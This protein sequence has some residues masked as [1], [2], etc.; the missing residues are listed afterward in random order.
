MSWT[1]ASLVPTGGSGPRESRAGHGRERA[2]T[3]AEAFGMAKTEEHYGKEIEEGYYPMVAVKGDL[4]YELMVMEVFDGKGWMMLDVST[5]LF[6]FGDE[7][8]PW[9][10]EG[11]QRE[12]RREA[13]LAAEQPMWT[14][15][16]N[17]VSLE[18]PPAIDDADV[19]WSLCGQW[20]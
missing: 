15:N 4:G 17:E 12:F 9:W 6:D 3:M 19:S 16:G 5:D 10:S 13:Q 8:N 11:V 14:P 18:K 2:G 1:R 7:P 20:V